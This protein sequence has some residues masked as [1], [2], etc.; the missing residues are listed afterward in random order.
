MNHICHVIQYVSLVTY[1]FFCWPV[2]LT[3]GVLLQASEEALRA[4]E[5]L[6]HRAPAAGT[7]GATWWVRWWPKEVQRWFVQKSGEIF[8]HCLDGAKHLGRYGDFNNRPQ[9]VSQISEA[10]PVRCEAGSWLLPGRGTSCTAT[11]SAR[12]D[13]AMGKKWLLIM[14]VSKNRGTPKSSHFN[15]VFH[16]KPSILGYPY[17]WKHPYGRSGHVFF[18]PVDL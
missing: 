3:G 4:L 12:S 1:S 5:L 14:G 8:H 16:Y 17:F 13:G 9:L 15:R 11:T 7:G 10:S 18:F 6:K 2:N